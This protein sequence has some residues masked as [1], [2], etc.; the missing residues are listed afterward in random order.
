MRLNILKDEIFSNISIYKTNPNDLYIHIRP[1]DIF[2]KSFIS[3]YSHPHC[4]LSKNYQ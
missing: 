3:N 2:I 4:F 1:G